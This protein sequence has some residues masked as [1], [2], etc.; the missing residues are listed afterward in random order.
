M[1]FKCQDLQSRTELAKEART[2][3]HAHACEVGAVTVLD[4]Q[5]RHLL[6]PE[7]GNSYL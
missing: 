4:S 7:E 3:L 2:V 6:L 1:E 5:W